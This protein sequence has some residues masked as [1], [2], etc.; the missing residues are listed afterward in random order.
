MNL[1]V[2]LFSCKV[3]NYNELYKKVLDYN[4]TNI[5]NHNHSFIIKTKINSNI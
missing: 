1:H 5:L 2:E 3:N 4:W